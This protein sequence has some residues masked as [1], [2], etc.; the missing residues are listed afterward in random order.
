MY[1]PEYSVKTKENVDKQKDKKKGKKKKRNDKQKKIKKSNTCSKINK[2]S[3]CQD[4]I[5]SIKKNYKSWLTLCV[6]IYIISYDNLLQGYMTFVI[7]MILAYL[8]HRETHS[9]RNFFTIAHHYHH[10]HNNFLSH[11]IQILNELNAPC[12]FHILFTYCIPLLYD[13]WS[14]IFFY[15]FYTSI[16]NINYSLFHVNTIHEMHHSYP[17]TNIGP[18]ICDIV[19]QSKNNVPG[20]TNHIEDTNHYIYNIIIGGIIVIILQQLYK[21]E[22]YSSIMNKI[23]NNI[24]III[25][26]LLLVLSSILCYTDKHDHKYIKPNITKLFT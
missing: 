5:T 26:P 8:L 12:I 15:I 23:A 25:L 20:V 14:L 18:D 16:H 1:I 19:F 9:I 7:S 11:F 13:S 10:E 3:T 21:T 6:M 22:K 2:T 4:F 17:E 24:T